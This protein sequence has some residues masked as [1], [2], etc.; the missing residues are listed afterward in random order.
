MHSR[1]ALWKERSVWEAPASLGDLW[2]KAGRSCIRSSYALWLGDGFK[3]RLPCLPHNRAALQL[4]IW[5]LLDL[6]SDPD[7]WA[8]F[9]AWPQTC[10][11]TVDLSGDLDSC[12]SLL[13]IAGPA[14]FASLWCCWTGP[15]SV[16][17]LPL[18]ALLLSCWAAGHSPLG[19]STFPWRSLTQMS[20]IRNTDLYLNQGIMA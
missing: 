11:I 8:D 4:L 9:L 2:E 19:S 18:L 20:W 15:L 5:T 16:R 17:P 3:R 14:L 12:L 7:P 6:D 13:T 10:L 1:P